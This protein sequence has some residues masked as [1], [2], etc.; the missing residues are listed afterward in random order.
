MAR[1]LAQHTMMQGCALLY[2]VS[3]LET[4]HAKPICLERT[5]FLVMRQ[6]LELLTGV[7]WVSPSCI[8]HTWE[9]VLRHSPRMLQRV[10]VRRLPVRRCIGGCGSLT[11]HRQRFRGLRTKID[12]F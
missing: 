7:K 1:F 10:Q 6:K 8:Q 9:R 4:I 11:R 3:R 5:D 12:E 2:E